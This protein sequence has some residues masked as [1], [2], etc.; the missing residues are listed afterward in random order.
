M[1]EEAQVGGA[2][3]LPTGAVVSNPPISMPSHWTPNFAIIAFTLV[4]SAIVFAWVYSAFVAPADTTIAPTQTAPTATPFESDLAVPT[5]PPT[6]PPPSPTATVEATATRQADTGSRTND[7]DTT[8]DQPSGRSGDNVRDDSNITPAATEESQNVETPEVTPTQE[9]DDATMTSISITATSSIWVTVWADDQVVFDGNLGAG[10]S[11]GHMAAA[12]FRVYTSQGSSTEFT[13][14]CGNEFYMG[15]EQ[16]QA[17][18]TLTRTE[19]SCAP[20]RD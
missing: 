1:F 15:S 2:G 16:G 5:N 10:E 12:N 18:Y 17:N 3:K 6:Q 19:D 20:I 14:A 9:I 11:T 7:S 4:L 13:N 8:T